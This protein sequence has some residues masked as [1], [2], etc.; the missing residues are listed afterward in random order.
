MELS[1]ELLALI[2]IG[3]ILIINLVTSAV[4]RNRR[5][6]LRPIEAYSV[7][8]RYTSESV[9]SNEPIHI[10]VG[11]ASPGDESTLLALFS[12]EF[13]YYLTL[14]V[15]VGQAP[16]ITTSAPASVPLAL[17]TSYRAYREERRRARFTPFRT[18]WY[19]QGARSLAYAAALMAMQ[20]EDKVS[21]NVLVG[22]YGAELALVLDAA[23]RTGKPTVAVSDQL[24][25]QAIAY[26]LSDHPL[27]GEEVF[28]VSSY[29]SEA[30][31]DINRSLVVDRARWLLIIGMIAL[32]AVPDALQIVIGG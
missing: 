21:A 32:L 31:G 15:A 6:P 9:E 28:A 27:I 26:A 18:R 30:S 2:V 23:Y 3:L 11:S 7:L 12:A 5:A 29:L 1:Q 25:G 10:A 16:I 13:V 24:D 22:R 17:T 19:P 14:E 4:G 8:P 20:T